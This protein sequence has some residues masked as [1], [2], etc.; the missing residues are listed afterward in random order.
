MLAHTVA[1]MSTLTPPPQLRGRTSRATGYT[2]VGAGALA[3]GIFEG[4][5]ARLVLPLELV[6]AVEAR[7]RPGGRRTIRTSG[8]AHLATTADFAAEAVLDRLH[9]DHGEVT[10]EVRTRYAGRGTDTRE[11]VAVAVDQALCL[12]LEEH[13][14]V[15]DR[16]RT[17]T[18]ATAQPS[19]GLAD[20]RPAIVSAQ[21]QVLSTFDTGERLSVVLLTPADATGAADTPADAAFGTLVPAGEDLAAWLCTTS[22]GAVEGLVH[23]VRDLVAPFDDV[24]GVVGGHTPTSPILVLLPGDPR[25]LST[26]QQVGAAVRKILPEGWQATTT[27]TGAAPTL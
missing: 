13:T 27:R 2:R 1:T 7:V 9:V 6:V 8:P 25:Y 17:A 23:D 21:G 11:A 26:C 24:L 3:A 5:H 20:G 16:A 15:A 18:Q 10:L 14:T 22:G 4:Q 12:A 19:A